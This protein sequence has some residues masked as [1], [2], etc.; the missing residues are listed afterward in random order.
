MSEPRR[1]FCYD[2]G[3]LLILAFFCG[4]PIASM[5]LMVEYPEWNTKLYNL[6]G[7]CFSS[8]GVMFD[9]TPDCIDLA[10]FCITCGAI[11]VIIAFICLIKYK[12][13]YYYGEYKSYWNT[14]SNRMLMGIIICSFFITA[15]ML[16]VVLGQ[17]YD[18]VGERKVE[19]KY[20]GEYN[21][22][23]Y[24]DPNLGLHC[25]KTS[26][27]KYHDTE[28]FSSPCRLKYCANYYFYGDMKLM[29][30]TLLSLFPLVVVLVAGLICLV[31]GCFVGIIICVMYGLMRSV[32]WCL[33]Q[34]CRDSVKQC[35][36]DCYQSHW[37]QDCVYY[38]GC[39][40]PM[41]EPNP[42]TTVEV[43]EIKIEE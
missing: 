33:S 36:R 41:Q 43:E 11:H 31:L 12:S 32:L 30:N 34:E 35:A 27:P 29:W 37:I 6:P 21:G 40:K 39:Y 28:P 15:P 17:Q 26:W 10:T 18:V 42:T 5:I 9:C 38:F 3:Y 13:W 8:H 22:G 16:I 7:K 19:K 23:F 2:A 14:E 24:V 1:R 4:G 20:T 25:D